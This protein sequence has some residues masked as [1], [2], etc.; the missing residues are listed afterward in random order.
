MEFKNGRNCITETQMN[1]LQTE[2]SAVLE[3]LKPYL[4]ETEVQVQPDAAGFDVGKANELI[5]ELQPLLE[6]GNP[7]CL[8]MINGLRLIPGS[9]KLISKMEDFYFVA[10]VEALQELK[11]NLLAS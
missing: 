5:K 7:D 6:S 2:L 9:G 1:S 10:A 8:K 11:E 4:A 3:D